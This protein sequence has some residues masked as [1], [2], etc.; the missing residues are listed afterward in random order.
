MED[1]ERGVY[2]SDRQSWLAAECRGLMCH[3]TWRG[4]VKVKFQ[5]QLV[6]VCTVI[7]GLK[8]QNN[9]SQ[10]NS[11]LSHKS[12]INT[13]CT[14]TCL[15]TGSMIGNGADKCGAMANK[16]ALSCNASFTR[17]YCKNKKS[18]QLTGRIVLRH[19]YLCYFIVP[20]LM[21]R[22]GDHDLQH[23]HLPPNLQLF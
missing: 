13:C 4:Q 11:L 14:I 2:C 3:F 16:L 21:S 8:E 7:V 20:S 18:V 6:K 5:F 17:R 15:Q 9:A 10:L 23:P 19:K 1:L 22:V 12:P